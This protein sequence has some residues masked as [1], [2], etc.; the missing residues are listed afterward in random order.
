M[1][2]N[3]DDPSVPQVARD[4]KEESAIWTLMQ[5]GLSLQEARDMSPDETSRYFA[6]AAGWR[7]RDPETGAPLVRPGVR[8]ATQADFDRF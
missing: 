8:K 2:A 5:L 3:E 1:D 4:F 6:V 7:N